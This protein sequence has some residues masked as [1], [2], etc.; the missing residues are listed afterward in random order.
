MRLF[1]GRSFLQETVLRAALLD[2]PGKV[3]I[4]TR[5]GWVD[6]AVREV[7]SLA[8]NGGADGKKIP[9]EKFVIIGEPCGKNTAP[10]VA[11]VCGYLLETR[12]GSP[13]AEPN[14]LVLPSDHIITDTENFARDVEVASVCS[15]EKSVVVFGIPPRSPETGFGYMET[16]GDGGKIAGVVHFKEKPDEEAAKEYVRSGKYYWNS[17]LYGVRAD[18]FLEELEKYAPDVFRAFDVDMS[19]LTWDN[20]GGIGVLRGA[21]VEAAYRDTPSVSI[22]YAVSEKSGR[23]VMVKAVFDWDD[24]GTWDSLAKYGE[25]A[26]GLAAEFSSARNFVYADMPVALCGVEDLCVIIQ[27]GKALVMKKGFGNEVKKIAENWKE[28]S[29]DLRKT[30]KNRS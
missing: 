22:D 29:G 3:V 21:A 4:V 24:A 6:A 25:A 30:G 12:K 10:A 15:R 7:R 1:G 13:L 26:S 11:L 19:G 17:G 16:T 28:V 18:V 2:V 5:D 8:G 23:V 14:V 27:N 9:L 20:H